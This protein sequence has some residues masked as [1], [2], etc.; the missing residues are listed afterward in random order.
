MFHALDAHRAA[1]FGEALEFLLDRLERT[2]G[3]SRRTTSHG[4]A[5]GSRRID[6]GTPLARDDHSNGQASFGTMTTKSDEGRS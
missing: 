5:R 4:D 1:A 2:L 3:V 6:A